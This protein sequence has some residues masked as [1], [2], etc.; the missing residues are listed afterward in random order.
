LGQVGAVIL[1]VLGV[2]TP[3]PLKKRAVV[4]A[5]VAVLAVVGSYITVLAV[6]VVLE[7]L[8]EPIGLPVR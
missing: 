8:G 2:S 3:A 6:V 5:T 7:L 4:L 1:A